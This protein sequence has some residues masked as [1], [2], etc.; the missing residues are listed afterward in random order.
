[1]PTI[2]RTEQSL[3][4]PTI[5]LLTML[6]CCV[7]RQN[8]GGMKATYQGKN[9]FI[10]F[11]HREGIS[12]IIGIAPDGRFIAVELKVG[13]NKTTERQEEFLAEVRQR[14]GIAIVAY[15]LDEVA[16]QFQESKQ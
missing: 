6:G 12:D 3:I 13:K 15:D 2:K 5:D 11:S 8:A 4:K 10:K 14:G 9:R 1:M 7:W 16:K